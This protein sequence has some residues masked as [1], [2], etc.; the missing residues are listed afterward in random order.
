MSA[1][2]D[3]NTSSTAR[4]VCP[5]SI[6][7]SSASPSNKGKRGV[8][9]HHLTLLG[10]LLEIMS[11]NRDPRPLPFLSQH[12]LITVRQQPPQIPPIQPLPIRYLGTE[13][14][15]ELGPL[16]PQYLDAHIL[17]QL[18]RGVK[19]GII[20]IGPEVEIAVRDDAVEQQQSG[21][22]V[23]LRIQAA[24]GAADAI[25][26][27]HDAGFLATELLF[28]LADLQD[29][30]SEIYN[31][32]AD[33]MAATGFMV[34]V[35]RVTIGRQPLPVAIVGEQGGP[36]HGCALALADDAGHDREPGGFVRHEAVEED[37]E[38]WRDGV[39]CWV[40]DWWGGIV[41]A[42]ERVVHVGAGLVRQGKGVMDDLTGQHSRWSGWA[43]HFGG[44]MAD[45]KVNR[46]RK[47][48]PW[49]TGAVEMF[50][51]VFQSSQPKV[52]FFVEL[53]SKF[54]GLEYIPRRRE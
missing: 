16:L 7:S 34:G 51:S 31:G 2:W 32:V 39:G 11:D 36:R 4:L 14:L 26:H 37:D 54:P 50:F 15:R 27:Q 22:G 9:T 28:R 23:L 46:R 47:S 3:S 1:R 48:L 10:K 18:L 49:T 20:R 8:F 41:G 44:R 29:Q 52:L 38:D 6:D 5:C 21:A 40:W 53:S 33:I 42:G 43:G 12:R 17:G 13:D 45:R 24:D 19:P 25:R 30:L 35:L